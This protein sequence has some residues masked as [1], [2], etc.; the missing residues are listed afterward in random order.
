MSVENFLRTLECPVNADIEPV[1]IKF[2][3]HVKDR[4]QAV[5]AAY[6][7]NEVAQ[8][9][10]YLRGFHKDF[11]DFSLDW[12][13]RELQNNAQQANHP[14]AVAMKKDARDM[15]AGL[16]ANIVEFALAY[17]HINRFIILLREEIRK[18]EIKMGAD[19]TNMKWSSDVGNAISK[20][21]KRK[22]D[23]LAEMENLGQARKILEAIEPEFDKFKSALITLF[24]AE[25]AA[26]L[27]RSLVSAFRTSDDMKIRKTLRTIKDAKKRFGMDQK[28]HQG[29]IDQIEKSVLALQAVFTEQRDVL[30]GAD[31]R[32][33]LKPIETDLAYNGK[34]VELRQIK[35]FLAKYHLPY[36][37]SK[38]DSLARLKEKMLVIGSL[39][40]LMTMYR[41][42]LA[43][44]A[45]PLSTL[46][47]IRAYEDAVV[48]KAKYLLG[49]HFQEI[50]NIRRDAGKAVQ[51][52][53]DGRKEFDEIQQMA[54]E[55][56]DGV[57]EKS[58][59]AA[60]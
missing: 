26:Q 46:E 38:L 36:M 43:G 39:E 19:I 25:K 14:D 2:M 34:I 48:N 18:E 60:Y 17:M 31:E 3:E 44:L 21:R 49:S 24:G 8:E 59:K 53:R 51:E 9:S 35:G 41:Q 7:E 15:L 27:T 32:L 54:L 58:A 37:Q 33:Y 1:E 20:Y 23:I 10:D 47:E 5:A 13:K 57:D 56:I 16:Q 22:R 40:S 50:P 52:F 55:T 6:D 28:T 45:R 42:L 12:T 30:A 4:I 29:H 11:F